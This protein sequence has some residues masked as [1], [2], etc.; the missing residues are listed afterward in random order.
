MAELTEHAGKMENFM[1]P[2]DLKSL[3]RDG[4]NHGRR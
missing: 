4:G 2:D 3:R 1:K